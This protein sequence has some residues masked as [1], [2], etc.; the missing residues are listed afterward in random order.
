MKNTILALACLA[1]VVFFGSCTKSSTCTCVTH[2]TMDG[3][4]M[5]DDITTTMTIDGDCKDGN[6]SITTQG[7][8]VTVTCK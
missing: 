6:S 5:L 8:L 2:S 4:V 3:E 7:M 1:L